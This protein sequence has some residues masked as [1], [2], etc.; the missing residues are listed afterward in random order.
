[1]TSA[2]SDGANTSITVAAAVRAHGRVV[3]EGGKLG[4]WALL[5][6]WGQVI[7]EDTAAAAAAAT[8]RWG[9][10]IV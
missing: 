9:K 2:C 4:K 10:A 8:L 5:L 6:D 3:C 1:M 7:E